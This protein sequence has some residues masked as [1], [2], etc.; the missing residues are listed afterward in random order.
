[1]RQRGLNEPRDRGHDEVSRDRDT[2]TFEIDAPKEWP[3]MEIACWQTPATIAA[4][5]LSGSLVLAQG[6]GG[7]APG[8]NPSNPNDMGLR[9]NQ[10]DMTLPGA[11]NPHDL[12]RSRSAPRVTSPSRNLATTSLP[13]VSSSL[14]HTYTVEPAKKVTRSKHRAAAQKGR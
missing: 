4:L 13:P 3:M 12:V 5:L 7:Y 10:S 2:A 8:V 9:A 11:S 14:A 6:V 1:M